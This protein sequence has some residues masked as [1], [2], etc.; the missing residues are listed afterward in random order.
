MRSID[1]DR[2]KDPLRES[3]AV[4]DEAD[5]EMARLFEKRMA[6]VRQ[7]ALY[8][9]E[10]GLPIL[11]P[12]RER[13]V[14][15]R[16]L[17]RIGDESLRG[18]YASFL[19]SVMSVSKSFQERL[20]KARTL[21]DRA[22][23]GVIIPVNL[24]K[25]SY[26]IVLEN[27]CLRRAG[28][29]LPLQRKVFLVTDDG[30]PESYAQTVAAQCAECEIL[31]LPRG[32]S[33]KS[34]ENFRLLLSR[35]LSFGLSRGD[36]VAAV[37]GGAAGDLAGFAA[38]CYMRGIDFYNI[39]TTLL[40]QMDAS[41]GGKTAID[42]D[43]VKNAVGAFYQP[44][45]VL[46]D[47]DTLSTLPPRQI[48]SGLAEAV[49]MALCLDEEGFALLD[50]EQPEKHLNEIIERALR[51]KKSIVEKDEREQGLRRVLNFGHTLGHAIESLQGKE[52]LQHGECVALGMLPM[53]SPPV[54]ERLLPVLKKLGLPTWC[55]LDAEQV[56]QAVFHDKKRTGSQVNAVLVEEIGRYEFRMMTFGALKDRYLAW[57]GEEKA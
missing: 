7:I 54:R 57:F 56:L 23:G 20:I 32:E 29:Y 25:N 36:C 47:P 1:A 14:I 38:A 41:V 15:E 13:E 46:I 42:L 19:E 27:G 28:E 34:F 35:M 26:D 8:K 2:E 31:R 43:G 10:R 16:N 12:G 53:C 3:R 39:P 33:S 22:A 49:K 11:D 30:V 45:R 18:D 44:R 50:K 51:L 52:G 5:R 40:S 24:G 6:A 55:A 37:G 17:A 4:I 48:A 9:Q 21:P